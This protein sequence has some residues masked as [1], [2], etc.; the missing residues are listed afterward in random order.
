MSIARQEGAL[1]SH[2]RGY[3]WVEVAVL[4]KQWPITS[5]RLCK[6]TVL[7]LAFTE[8]L[9]YTRNEGFRTITPALP[10][11]ALTDLKCGKSKMARP[12]RFELPTPGFVGRCSIQLSYGRVMTG[13]WLR[14]GRRS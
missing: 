9:A 12:E 8:R 4:M 6:R 1:I 13:G 11:K 7:K 5:T 3:A 14:R 10:F 2:F